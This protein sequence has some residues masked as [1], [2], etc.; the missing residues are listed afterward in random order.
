[1][2][3]LTDITKKFIR[4]H[5]NDDPVQLL[6][7]GH[8]YPELDIQFVATQI[9]AKQRIKDKIPVF[10]LNDD[11][12]Y[13]TQL[14]LEQ[15]SSQQ[16][17]FHKSEIAGGK[18]LIDLTG[19]FGVDFYFMSARFEKSIYVERQI[20]LC[21]LAEHNFK[22]LG[23]E[24]VEIINTEANDYLNKMPF[25]DMV[26]VDPHRR[27]Q[28]GKKTVFIRDCEPDMTIIVREL[29][30]KC[31]FLLIKLS[32]MIDLSSAINDLPGTQQIDI[33]SVDN[34]CKEVLFLLGPED[35]EQPLIRCFNYLKNG[36]I[37][38]TEFL[39]LQDDVI[40]EF[41]DSPATYL[42]EPNA[43]LLKSGSFN[44]LAQQN[45]LKKFHVNTHLY[46][47]VVLKN[48]FPGRIFRIL[49][50]YD[51]SKS[52]LKELGKCHPTAHISVRNFP[53]TVEELRKRTKIKDGGEV[54]IFGL[55]LLNNRHKILIC[56]KI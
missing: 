1:M 47:S 12:I 44:R 15:S 6:L 26:F 34:E 33:L 49:Y 31:R 4:E 2:K 14:P 52:S 36:I 7:Q 37:Q 13:P 19:G 18:Q 3:E 8:R 55:T 48:N 24:N 5:A 30:R 42:Y 16:T 11:V 51:L 22:V 38:Q 20:E 46:T 40:P 10:F 9:A 17:A 28:Q 43:A 56:S 32:P 45:G 29:R 54:Y 25:A 21:K 23:R 50:V 53:L 27:N 39:G 41:T 35:V